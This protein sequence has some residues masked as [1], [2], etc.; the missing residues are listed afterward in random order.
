[1]KIK[2]NKWAGWITF[3]EVAI[4]EVF[5]YY[6]KLYLR[7]EQLKPEHPNAVRMD[8]GD[9]VYFFNDQQGCTIVSGTFVQGE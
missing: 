4:G 3:E 2:L 6:N 9:S 7:C 1:M 5:M 8:N